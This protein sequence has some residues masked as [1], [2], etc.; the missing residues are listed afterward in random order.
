METLHRA[1]SAEHLLYLADTNAQ[2][3]SL[4]PGYAPLARF[5]MPP[6]IWRASA[7]VSAPGPSFDAVRQT[8]THSYVRHRHRQKSTC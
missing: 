1:P 4:V 8:M 2:Q 7:S 5:L 6:L 3:L